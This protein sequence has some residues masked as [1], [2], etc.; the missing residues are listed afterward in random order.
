M[1]L[2]FQEH[3]MKGKTLLSLQQEQFQLT[4]LY[5]DTRKEKQRKTK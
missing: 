5:M 1:T 2:S 4:E 3:I